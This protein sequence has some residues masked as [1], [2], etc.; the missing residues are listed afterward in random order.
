MNRKRILA[1]MMSVAM[2]IA[3]IGVVYAENTDAVTTSDIQAESVFTPLNTEEYKALYAMGF[4]GEDLGKTD[5]TAYITRAQFTGYLFKLAGYQLVEHKTEDIPFIDIST[6]TPYY[7]EICTMCELGIVNGTEPNMFSPKAHVTYAQACKLIVE[8][9]GYKTYAEVSHGGFPQGHIAM[10]AELEINKG[11]KNVKWD[12]EL[13]AEDAVKMLFNAGN[14][15]VMKF[16]GLDENGN[17]KYEA[18]GET[19]FESNDIYY[20]EG[21]MMSNGVASLESEDVA[22][23]VTIIGTERYVSADTDLTELLGCMVKYYYR[24]DEVEKKLLWATEYSRFNSSVKLR[25]IDLARDDASYTVENVVYYDRNGKKDNYRVSSVA[26][27][28]YNNSLYHIP[29]VG[30]MKPET[31]TMRLIDNNDDD[32]YDIVIIEEFNNIFI[33]GVSTVNNAIIDKYGD[34]LLLNNYD[35]VKIMKD[36]EEITFA[37]VPMNALA[38]YI[39]DAD[40]TKIY[41]YITT[42]SSTGQLK[43]V[44]TLR[45]NPKYV[46]EE[47]EYRVSSTFNRRMSDYRSYVTAKANQA[48]Q[49]PAPVVEPVP[50]AITPQ[51][52]RTYT[53]YI[54]IDGEIAEIQAPIAEKQYAFLMSAKEGPEY[55]DG[56]VYT[57]ILLSNGSKVSAI[58]KKKLIVDGKREDATEIIARA[59]TS[60]S[61]EPQ[62]VMVVMNDEGYLT[63]VDF[64]ANCTSRTDYPYGFNLEEFSLDEE[65]NLFLRNNEGYNMLAQKYMIY[66]G[67]VVFQ[68]VNGLDDAEPYRTGNPGDIGSNQT[69]TMKVYDIKDDLTVSAIYIPEAIN[70]QAMWIEGVMLVNETD[71]VYQDGYEVRRVSGYCN[72]AYQQLSEIKPGVMPADVARGDMLELSTYE[73]K[74]TAVKRIMKLS[75]LKESKT[76]RVITGSNADSNPSTCFAQL[77]NATQSAVTVLTPPEWKSKGNITAFGFRSNYKILVQ[78]YDTRTDEMYTADIADIHQIYKSR[79]DGSLPD[80]D[81]LVMAVVM[82]RYTSVRE[83]ILI[84]Y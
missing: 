14:A 76:P 21:I 36:G 65:G 22:A 80:S 8:V 56:I 18:K 53:Y 49:T 4:V 64:A 33:K 43:S 61:F 77:Y 63:E 69:A 81:N 50:Y 78:V 30:I 10:A 3:S 2:F 73:N 74:V 44:D 83:L 52:G 40:Q 82:A 12:S 58:A 1:F 6:A 7:N 16:A 24:D 72:G 39:E 11:V 9:L 32:I 13:T 57:R 59:S 71:I 60:G 17:P 66:S 68:K 42:A 48:T 51:P 28:L 62:V 70:A 5:A 55:E 37:E 38:S 41:I 45:G 29:T 25:A 79:A 34:T 20:S 47:N 19:L 15:E 26:I 54:D 27:V 35:F 46:F 75:E 31:G 23:N 84:L 67:V